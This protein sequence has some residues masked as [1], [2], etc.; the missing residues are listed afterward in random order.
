MKSDSPRVHRHNRLTAFT[1][2]TL[3]GTCRRSKTE[4]TRL[5]RG[6]E[7]LEDEQF[8][9]SL[10]EKLLADAMT[11][12]A[13]ARQATPIRSRAS[14]VFTMRRVTYAA[15]F[16][17]ILL[18]VGAFLFPRMQGNA[19]IA[20][21]MQAM[22]QVKTCHFTGSMPD[23]HGG[24]MEIE[25]WFKAPDRL[26]VHNGDSHESYVL[27]GKEIIIERDK[28]TISKN[29][30]DVQSIF[31]GGLFRRT[32]SLYQYFDKVDV[33]KDVLPNGH[34]ALVITT[35]EKQRYY[36]G[37]AVFTIDRNTD[38]MVSIREY[39]K[40][41][42]LTTELDNFEYDVPIPDSVFKVEIPDSLPVTDNTN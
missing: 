24:R 25:G 26:Y 3:C 19:A 38:L 36:E 28:V 35:H 15:G 8:P 41:G 5:S 42:E 29:D 31:V 6:I 17:V 27:D 4:W 9:P 7:R 2:K 16:V 33:K 30:T 18:L 11:A 12:S 13:K 40:Q 34:E 23:D 39:D 14:E 21:A 22:R 37:T 32:M 10:D 20:D 1:H